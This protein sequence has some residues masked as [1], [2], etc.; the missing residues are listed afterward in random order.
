MVE[1]VDSQDRLAHPT[2]LDTDKVLQSEGNRFLL[3]SL[4]EADLNHVSV[5]GAVAIAA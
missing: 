4:D 5:V 2:T 1:E 3:N